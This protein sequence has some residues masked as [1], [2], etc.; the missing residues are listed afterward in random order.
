VCGKSWWEN[1][2][3]IICY[4]FHRLQQGSTEVDVCEKLFFYYQTLS[5]LIIYI[6]SY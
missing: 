4:K 3:E 1:L 6:K 5:L 2:F